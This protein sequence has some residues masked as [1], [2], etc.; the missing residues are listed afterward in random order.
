MRSRCAEVANGI[1]GVHT[2]G[3]ALAIEAALASERGREARHLLFV[4]AGS[5]I[6]VALALYA[7]PLAGSDSSLS[8]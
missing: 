5:G 6:T 7:N 2:V 4:A 1:A 8:L 3:P